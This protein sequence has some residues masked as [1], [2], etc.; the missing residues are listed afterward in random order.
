MLNFSYQLMLFFLPNDLSSGIYGW[1]DLC[2]LW[3]K[4]GFSCDRGWVVWEGLSQQQLPRGMRKRGYFP[5]AFVL[6]LFF[7]LEFLWVF[8]AFSASFS[9]SLFLPS[10]IFSIQHMSFQRKKQSFLFNQKRRAESRYFEGNMKG[11]SGHSMLILNWTVTMAVLYSLPVFVLVCP[12]ERVSVLVVRSTV[13]LHEFSA[14]L[15]ITATI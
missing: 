14:H 2:W 8:S 15:H 5:S 6:F 9:P 7:V 11:W 13:F 3:K 10:H 1:I 12:H 4:Q